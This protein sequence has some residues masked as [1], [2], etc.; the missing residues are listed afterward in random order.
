MT[1]LANLYKPELDNHHLQTR[2]LLGTLEMNQGNLQIAAVF[3]AKH[4]YSLCA[5][6]VASIAAALYFKRNDEALLKEIQ[7]ALT[8]AVKQK[9]LRSRM[10]RGTRHYEV[11]YK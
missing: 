5:E 3:D 6:D 11:N 7:A 8:S 4:A 9:V 2:Q 10:I 1:T